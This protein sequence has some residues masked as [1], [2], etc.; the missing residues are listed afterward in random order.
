MNL[1]FGRIAVASVALIVLTGCEVTESGGEIELEKATV[2]GGQAPEEVGLTDLI[3]GEP[4]LSPG[5]FATTSYDSSGAQSWTTTHESCARGENTEEV[6]LSIFS[7]GD[8]SMCSLTTYALDGNDLAAVMQCRT[9]AGGQTQ[10]EI[11]GKLGTNEMDLDVTLSGDGLEPE[12]RTY[13]QRIKRI[14]DCQ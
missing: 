9:E 14:Q 2:Y 7:L 5:Y 12:G 3:N 8:P 4:R 1:T 6:L 13:G 10:T 11:S